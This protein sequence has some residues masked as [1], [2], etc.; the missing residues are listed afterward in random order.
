MKFFNFFLI[1]IFSFHLAYASSAKEAKEFVN[2]IAEEVLL[3]VSDR[4]MNDSTKE[5]K[6]S[7]LFKHSVDIKWIGRFALGRFAKII[8]PEQQVKYEE[9]FEKL[10]IDNYIPNF[11]KYTK[12]S[13]NIVN[14]ISSGSGEFL[15]QTEIIR[16]DKN[17]LKVDYAIKTSKD[18]KYQ[19]F[20]IVA[21]GVSLI[22]TQRNEYSSILSQ[23]DIDYLIQELAKKLN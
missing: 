8:T 7:E 18:N 15:V 22:S 14:V 10:L 20:D 3:I 21:E 17:N 11:K 1:A 2:Q 23:H 16:P 6:L 9:L 5:L 12:E 4:E 13:F 19:I